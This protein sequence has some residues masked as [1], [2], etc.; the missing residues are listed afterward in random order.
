M[1]AY[2]KDKWEL[3]PDGRPK[4]HPVIAVGVSVER[5]GMV[6]LRLEYAETPEEHQEI[7][8]GRAKPKFLQVVMFPDQCRGTLAELSQAATLAEELERGGSLN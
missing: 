6:V 5:P 3:L 4:A 8:A 7:R 1:S 2:D